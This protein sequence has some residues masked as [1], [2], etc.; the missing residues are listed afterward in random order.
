MTPEAADQ[1]FDALNRLWSIANGGSGQCRYVAEFLLGLYN[2]LRF[3]FDL[4]SLR[5]LDSDIVRDCLAVLALDSTKV[6]EVHILL[7]LPCE[8]FEKLV[9][10]WE[11][12]ECKVWSNSNEEGR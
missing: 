6:G 7:G 11:I 8:R 12:E 5:A 4:T 1:H 3:P 10:D 2:G 9:S